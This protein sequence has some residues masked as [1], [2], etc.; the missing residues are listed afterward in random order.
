MI[1]TVATTSKYEKGN[2]SYMQNSVAVTECTKNL[3]GKRF[4]Y[5]SSMSEYH[6]IYWVCSGRIYLQQ[7][8]LSC[9]KNALIFVPKR[10]K[11]SFTTEEETTLLHLSFEYSGSLPF[12]KSGKQILTANHEVQD[13]LDRLYRSGLF[14]DVLPGIAES[15]LL[16]TLNEI[17]MSLSTEYSNRKLF[18]EAYEWIECHAKQDIIASDVA[19]AMSKSVAHLNRVV[20]QHTGESLSALIASRRIFEIQQLC[21]CKGI[22]TEEIAK[23]LNFSSPELLRKYYKYH[24]G[25]SLKQYLNSQ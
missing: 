3:Y 20:R 5:H 23:R 16:I 24:T 15:F 18:E 25:F 12:F 14:N 10:S 9:S 13:A 17:R 11:L 7:E 1:Y 4:L 6:A 19:A 2:R 21:S 22:T 8:A